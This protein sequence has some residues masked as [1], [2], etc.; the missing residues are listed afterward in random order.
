MDEKQFNIETGKVDGSGN[1][2]RIF[3][4]ITVVFLLVLNISKYLNTA[5]GPIPRKS[6]KLNHS[7]PVRRGNVIKL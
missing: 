5:Q 2:I 6:S 1:F 7:S 4:Y 3:G